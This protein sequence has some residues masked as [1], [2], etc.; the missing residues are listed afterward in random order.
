MLGQAEESERYY[1]EALE[2]APG[3]GSGRPVLRA[4]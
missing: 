3:L 4:H 2:I 1:R